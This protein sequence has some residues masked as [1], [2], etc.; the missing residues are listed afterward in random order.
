M[1]TRPSHVNELVGKPISDVGNMDASKIDGGGVSTSA[2]GNYTPTVWRLEW[3]LEI[4]KRVVSDRNLN[5]SIT[6]SDL[7]MATILIQWLVLEHIGIT[8]H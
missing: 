5:G 3:L 7:E 2:D 4:G 6:N 1:R 8:I